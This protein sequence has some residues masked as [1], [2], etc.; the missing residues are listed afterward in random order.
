MIKS[1]YFNI[2]VPVWGAWSIYGWPEG[3]WGI[4][5]EKNRIDYFAKRNKDVTVSYWKDKG[6]YAV[7]A[8]KV[9]EYPIERIKDYEKWVYI[10][11]KSI[12][13]K[14]VKVE[15]KSE[16]EEFKELARLGVFN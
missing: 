6:V 9:Q 15:R 1:N 12:L 2:R 5:L 10:I 14:E 16:E 4:G 13:K 11:P 7:S 8:Q 3:T